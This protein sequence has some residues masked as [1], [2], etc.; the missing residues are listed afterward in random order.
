MHYAVRQI[1]FLHVLYADVQKQENKKF[2]HQTVPAVT[3]F[4]SKIQV[5]AGWLCQEKHEIMCLEGNPPFI[6][7]ELKI[8]QKTKPQLFPY[9]QEGKF[10]F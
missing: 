7:K 10:I 3:L 5:H 2:M 9:S 6:D 8:P 1:K 4:W